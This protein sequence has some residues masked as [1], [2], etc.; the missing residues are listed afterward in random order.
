MWKYEL[1]IIEVIVTDDC[2]IIK[3]NSNTWES[4]NADYVKTLLRNR[5]VSHAQIDTAFARLGAGERSGVVWF[6]TDHVFKKQIAI[7][8]FAKDVDESTT[9]VPD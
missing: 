2:N 1:N 3:T 8:K 5:G 6:D 9:R 4:I 7:I